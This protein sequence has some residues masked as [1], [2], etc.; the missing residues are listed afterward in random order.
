MNLTVNNMVVRNQIAPKPIWIN[1]T[2]PTGPRGNTGPIG[3]INYGHTG[4]SY[5]GDTGPI[6]S[7]GF[8]MSYTG[9]TGDT[10]FKGPSY[11]G[12]TGPY[13]YTGICLTGITGDTGL[14]G[15]D[16]YGPTGYGITRNI[17]YKDDIST[18]SHTFSSSG[19]VNQ[20][21]FITSETLTENVY[22]L[23][24][25]F[26]MAVSSKNIYMSMFNAYVTDSNLNTLTV[27]YALQDNFL[28]MTTSGIYYKSNTTSVCNGSFM[29][30]LS[31]S[32]KIY[33]YV[34]MAYYLVNDLYSS[35]N[36]TISNVNIQYYNLIN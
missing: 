9:P 1:L 22:Y 21:I 16:Y 29:F 14:S 20:S 8:S 19:V 2:G 18:L 25:N 12:D 5:K 11:T 23:T 34:K 32:S 13:G 31:S 33:L 6:G 17:T 4:P 15:Y 30:K 24:F 3:M 10:G 26:D 35:N 27:Q 36:V 7:T 28:P